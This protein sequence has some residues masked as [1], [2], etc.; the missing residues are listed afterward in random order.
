MPCGPGGS[1]LR[2]TP[3]AQGRLHRGRTTT[4]LFALKAVKADEACNHDR[5][6]VFVAWTEVAVSISP[7]DVGSDSGGTRMRADCSQHRGHEGAEV[8][9]WRVMKEATASFL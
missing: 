1:R 4:R 3:D 8:H 9:S 6:R 7:S 2:E 5:R